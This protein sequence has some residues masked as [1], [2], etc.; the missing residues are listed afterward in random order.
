MRADWVS[1]W[2]QAACLPEQW[3]VCGISVPSLSVWHTFALENI[4][5]RYLCGGDADRDDAAGLF[6]FASHD[7]RGGRR[8]MLQARFRLRQMRRM[9]RRLR[10]LNWKELDCACSEYVETCTRGVSHWQKGGGKP[11]AAP[12]Q[13]HIVYRLS[14]GDPTKTAAAW[15]MP[16]VVARCLNDVAIEQGGDDSLMA[17]RAQEMEDEGLPARF[18]RGEMTEDEARK[19]IS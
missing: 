6:L 9:Y 11:C 15:D 17:E 10:N 3:D 7:M 18:W 12:Y 4:G 1:P 13:W 2:W 19:A 16:Y 5:N 14:G 8:L